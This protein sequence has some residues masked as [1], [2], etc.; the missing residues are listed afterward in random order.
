MSQSQRMESK[1]PWLRWVLGRRRRHLLWQPIDQPSLLYASAEETPKIGR[2]AV[3]GAV[4]RLGTLQ[5]VAVELVEF[6]Q[7]AVSQ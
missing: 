7:A 1:G 3:Q 2:G 4:R 6:E 5:Q